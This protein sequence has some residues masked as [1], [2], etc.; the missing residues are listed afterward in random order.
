[1]SGISCNGTYTHHATL[2]GTQVAT[3]VVL[4]CHQ[5][6]CNGCPCVLLQVLPKSPRL[7]LPCP[8]PH[9]SS[10]PFQ[11]LAHQTQSV[12]KGKAQNACYCWVFLQGCSAK[13]GSLGFSS[14]GSL[15]ICLVTKALRLQ[16]SPKAQT[17]PGQGQLIIFF[18]WCHDSNC[19]PSTEK[20]DLQKWS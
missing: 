16:T 1:M 11:S 4:C 18:F 13:A 9:S 3:T 5:W 2:H 14:G 10:L 12:T 17:I 19:P 20:A 7:F 8:L 6:Y 15:L